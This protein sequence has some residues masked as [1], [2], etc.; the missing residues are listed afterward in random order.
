MPMLVVVEIAAALSRRPQRDRTA[1][2][3]MWQ[4][5]ISEWERSSKINLYPLNQGR[6]DKAVNIA[7]SHRLRG[8]DSVITA[9]SDELSMPLKTFDTEILAR[10]QPASV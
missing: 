8:A 1:I 5:T 7:R 3:S 2:L 4:E 6:M 9:L 10:F